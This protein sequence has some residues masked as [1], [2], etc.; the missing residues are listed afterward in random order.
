MTTKLVGADDTTGTD[1]TAANYFLLAKF[2][3]E[4]SG[5]MTEFRIK[6][7]ASG[8]VKCALYADSGGEPAALITAMNTGQAVTGGQ[9][10]TLTF[11]STPITNGTTYWLAL[12]MATASCVQYVVSGGSGRR[13]RAE[14]YSGFS[15]PD[16]AG[17]GF[18]SYAGYYLV[19]GWGTLAVVSLAGLSAG[20]ASVSG[21]AVIAY[22][23][24]GIAQGVASVSG[25]V[26][27][28]KWLAG[29]SSGVASVAASLSLIKYLSGLFTGL[30]TVAGVLWVGKKR[31]ERTL[32]AVRNLTALRNIEPDR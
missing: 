31:P 5:D 12:N 17:V 10:N 13:V 6:S 14:T 28:I 25:L 9:W 24:A 4:A 30:A 27:I 19:A 26:G 11:T 15:F 20:V 1:G 8:N 29:L 16:P 21:L 22:K 32:A 18:S 2:T 7:G 3:A 23:L